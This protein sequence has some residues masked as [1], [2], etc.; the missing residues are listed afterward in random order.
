MRLGVLL[1]LEPKAAQLELSL[2]PQPIVLGLRQGIERRGVEVLY[3]THYQGAGE[4]GFR[5][6]DRPPPCIPIFC[7]WHKEGEK[8]IE[9]QM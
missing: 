7:Q 3:K 9:K 6:I 4:Q 5:H 8:I 1:E 2:E